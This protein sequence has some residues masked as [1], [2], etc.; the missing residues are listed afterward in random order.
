M[1]IAILSCSAIATNGYGNITI[2]YCN[3]LYKKKIDF[4]LF[5]PHNHEVV[6]QHWSKNIKYSLPRALYSFGSFR[7]I[8][9]LFFKVNEFKNF[10]LIH[11]L[12]TNTSMIV[13]ARASFK[14]NIPLVVGEQGTYAA[15]P[16]LRKVSAYIYKF[17]IKQASVII[18]PSQFTKKIFCNFYGGREIWTKA[19][20]IENGVN[21]HRFNKFISKQKIKNKFVGVGALKDRKGFECAIYAIALAK[22]KIPNLTYTIIGDGPDTY[23]EKLLNLIT[24]LSL[25]D[26]V[27]LVGSKSGD[28]LVNEMASSYA[29]L[30]TPVSFNWN[31]EGYGIVY[32]E[33]NSLGLPV[34]GSDSGGVSSAITNGVNGYLANEADSYDTYKKIIH[35]CSD[36]FNYQLISDQSVEF[37][38]KHDWS[39]VVNEF[40]KIYKRFG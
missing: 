23:R 7:I 32:L 10:S 25:E 20:V 16:F 33:A 21:F 36:T 35:I 31:F 19:C 27:K 22:E 15:I 38:R 28:Q 39:L 30:H 34:I 1:R 6:D 17:F 29:Y 13:A 37:A 3:E 24:E 5:L 8:S 14:F 2:N 4:I 9:D 11:S 18:F 40:L 12:F 26:S